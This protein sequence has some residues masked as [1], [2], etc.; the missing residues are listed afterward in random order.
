MTRMTEGERVVV[1]GRWQPL[2]RWQ[3]KERQQW[4]CRRTE[5]VIN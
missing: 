5:V 2:A 1:V 4:A 3:L